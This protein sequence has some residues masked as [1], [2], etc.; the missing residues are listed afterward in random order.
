MLSKLP[1]KSLGF[2]VFICLL[3]W[4]I[5]EF[6]PSKKIT[7]EEKNKKVE[8]ILGRPADTKGVDF[9]LGQS[10]KG[11]YISFS[12]QN[13][14][15]IYD[16]LKKDQG[17][18]VLDSVRL[19]SEEPRMTMTVIVNNAGGT[20]S[21]GDVSGVSLRRSKGIYKED[22]YQLAGLKMLTMEKNVLE[23]GQQYAFEKAGF[24]LND[25]KIYSFVLGAKDADLGKKTFDEIV[26]SVTLTA[27]D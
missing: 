10:Y 25:D 8:Q 24:L 18:N 19:D 27:S 15:K 2:I 6:Y 17:E 9:S 7:V 14:F 5:F 16:K 22:S 13:V 20:S 4:A 3:F 11:D 21:I 23:E 1:K 26:A 12:Y